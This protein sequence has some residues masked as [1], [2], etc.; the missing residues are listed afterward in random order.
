MATNR[1]KVFTAT[2]AN[3][4]NTINGNDILQQTPNGT[5]SLQGKAITEAEKKLLIAEASN[6]MQ[7]KLWRALKMDVQYQANKKM[8]FESKTEMD[9][10]AGKLFLYALDVME[11]RLKT[12]AK[13]RGFYNA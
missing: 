5:W 12:M 2:V 1:N 3:L 11:T 9:L 7:S 8:F 13:G 10:V 4:F 6:L